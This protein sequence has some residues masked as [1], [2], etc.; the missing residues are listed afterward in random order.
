MSDKRIEDIESR[1]LF[2]DQTLHDLN[3]AIYRQQ[4]QI[5]KLASEVKFLQ[6]RLKTQSEPLTGLFSEEEKPPHY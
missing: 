3:D 6:D 1:V 4:R 5:D 2:Q